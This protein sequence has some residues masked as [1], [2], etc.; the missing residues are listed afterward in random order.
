MREM[1]QALAAAAGR[2]A[3]NE[4]GDS[5]GYAGLCAVLMPP[6]LAA[7]FADA[8]TAT[9]TNQPVPPAAA[10]RCSARQTNPLARGRAQPSR[11]RT[12]R[13]AQFWQRDNPRRSPAIPP[14]PRAARDIL[15]SRFPGA[16]RARRRR[17]CAARRCRGPSGSKPAARLAV[18][19]C[20]RHR[21]CGARW[22][23]SAAASR[24]GSASSLRNAR[25]GSG[26][27]LPRR[28]PAR[29]AAAA[30]GGTRPA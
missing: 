27:P 12:S 23:R 1:K 5:R 15:A 19:R 10:R 14:S 25:P 4:E 8:G 9:Q 18:K 21:A 11:S 13:A 6:L 24:A 7:F 16:Q 3:G 2:G 22:R 29:S 17:P 20:R 28:S 26:S 30:H